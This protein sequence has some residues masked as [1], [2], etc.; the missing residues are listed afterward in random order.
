MIG[1]SN[2]IEKNTKILTGD[3]S[4]ILIENL[5]IWAQIISTPQKK[6]AL[7]ANWEENSKKWFQK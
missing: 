1:G 4:S 3:L 7:M 2:E 5:P 6:I